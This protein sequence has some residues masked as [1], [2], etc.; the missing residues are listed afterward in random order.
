MLKNILSVSGK[1]GLQKM[2]NNSGNTFIVESL[3]DGKRFAVYPSMKVTS[4]EDI[5]IYTTEEDVLLKDVF[6][7]IY[8]KSNGKTVLSHKEDSPKIVA[9]F[10]E[11]FPEYDKDRV[12]MSDLRKIINWYNILTEKGLLNFEKEEEEKVDTANEK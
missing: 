12:Y 9:F 7:K 1:P 4:L 6:K 3:L 2:I 8:D 5:S 11:V 10:E